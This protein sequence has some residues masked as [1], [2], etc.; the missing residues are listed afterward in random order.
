VKPDV[1]I[2]VGNDQMEMFAEGLVPTFS[3]YWGDTVPNRLPPDDYARR[4]PEG[5]R[6][7]MRAHAPDEPVEYPG[8]PELALHMLKAVQADGFDPAAMQKPPPHRGGWVSVPHA[9]GFIYHRLLKDQIPATVPVVQNTFYPP[10][11][12][13]IRR[14]IDFGRSLARAITSW[15]SD[16]RVAMIGSGGLTHFVIDE[17]VDQVILDAIRAGDAGR[18]EALTESAFQSG[19]SE[20]KNWIPVIGAMADLGAR[21][22]VVDYVPCYR[23]PAGTGNAMGFVYW[24]A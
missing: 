12:P 24:T 17:E 1:F 8:C 9:F 11:Q 21:P 13:S 20:A 6:I 4:W 10:N 7:A 3:I 18:L 19:T 23:S 15:D 2:V 14:S 5:I 16:A 22:T